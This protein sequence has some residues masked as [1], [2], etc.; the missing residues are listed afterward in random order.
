MF[1]ADYVLMEYGTGAIMAVPGHDQRDFEF[2]RKFDLPIRQ[3]VA[4]AGSEPEP[5]PDDAAFVDPVRGRPPGQ[6]GRPRRPD[7]GGREAQDHRAS[8]RPRAAASSPSTT[9]CATGCCRGSATGAARS[10]SS[11]APSCGLVPVP[12]DQ[13]PGRA[14]RR[15]GLP[16][17]GQEPAR[18]RDRLGR[19]RM[20]ALL[21]PGP[22]RDRHD[23][24][25]RR[26]LLVLP[27]LPR[28]AQL[29][30]AVRPRDR[31]PL[32]A[33]RPVHRRGRA[34]DPPPHVRPLLHQGAGRR[35]ADRRPG[36]LREPLHPGHDH[37]RRCT[38]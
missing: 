31:R 10:R 9:G 30:A 28:P 35:R 6:L 21:G 19:D 12:E 20:P 22:S 18:H 23:G 14:A 4:P 34:R 24:H 7:A 1:V 13:L 25:L 5:V 3:V 38:R 36:A 16:A 37:P 33:D 11:T 15:R 29:R 8:S 17:Q 27:P 32:D 26:L 2:A